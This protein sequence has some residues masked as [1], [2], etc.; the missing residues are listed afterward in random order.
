MPCFDLSIVPAVTW[1]SA[2][3][4]FMP[5]LAELISELPAERQGF[6]HRNVLAVLDIYLGFAKRKVNIPAIPKPSRGNGKGAWCF[7]NTGSI[8]LC[9]N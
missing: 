5:K 1:N 3:F 6:D 7:T 2:A 8:F 9:V 4:G